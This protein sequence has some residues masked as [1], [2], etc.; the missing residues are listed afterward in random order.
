MMHKIKGITTIS[1]HLSNVGYHNPHG[2][3]WIC[4]INK[5]ENEYWLRGFN[6]N[7]VGHSNYNI[8]T[9]TPQYYIN[10]DRIRC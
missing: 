8:I 10:G 4:K 7:I 9:N 6:H 3:A 2:P 1:Y 5:Y